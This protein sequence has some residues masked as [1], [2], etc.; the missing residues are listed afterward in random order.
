MLEVIA[1]QA[2]DPGRLRANNE[3]AMAAFT[4]KSQQEA[5]SHGW[6]FVVADG[7]GGLDL[8]DVAAARAASVMVGGFAHAPPGTLLPSLLQQLIQEAN[9]A[10][11]DEGLQRERRGKRMATTV[12]SCVL[13][14]DK[15]VIA[16]VGDSRCYHLCDGK[17]TAVTSDH[18]FVN[19]QLRMGLITPIEA[20]TSEIRN[21]LTRSL[22]PERFIKAD[23]TTLSLKPGDTLLLCTDGLY[24]GMYDEDILRIISQRKDPQQAAED[25]VSYAIEVDG[26]DNATAQVVHVSDIESATE[27]RKRSFRIPGI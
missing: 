15:A 16:H 8:G 26:S 27:Y 17:I 14:Y 23:T 22:G 12:V 3:D 24:G 19:E 9:A 18:T 5:R 7:V 4:P 25:L 2:T 13:R 1:G 20:A 21:V 10:V 11:H 6:M